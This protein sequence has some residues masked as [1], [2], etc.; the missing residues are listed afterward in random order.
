MSADIDRLVAAYLDALS[1]ADV[2]A[3][4]ALFAQDG[5]VDSP[6]YGVLPAR[7]FYP[8]LFADTAQSKLSLKATM[9]GERKGRT[10]ISFWFDFDWT[11]AN[12]EPAPFTVVDVAELDDRGLIAQLH[13]VYD[14]A[15]L[16]DSFN[17]QHDGAQARS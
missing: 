1:T 13:I 11:L 12:G 14:T 4:L 3:V 7:H 15:P 16:R 8:A 17:R 2:Q 9:T 5:V 6:L 10:V